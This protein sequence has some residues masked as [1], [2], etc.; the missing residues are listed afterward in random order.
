MNWNQKIKDYPI[1]K[2]KTVPLKID[3]Y[4]IKNQRLYHWKL[5]KIRTINL[6]STLNTIKIE[7]ENN[8]W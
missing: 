6:S 8:H 2:L 4:S 7:N 1:K 5:K 3:D